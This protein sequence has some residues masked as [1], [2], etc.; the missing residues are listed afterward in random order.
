MSGVTN[1]CCANCMRVQI[2]ILFFCGSFSASFS[3][4]FSGSFSASF[5]GSALSPTYYEGQND[6]FSSPSQLLFNG[7]PALGAL[8]GGIL[9]PVMYTI[10]QNKRP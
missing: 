9:P 8:T 2:C 7:R 4:S 6:M 3:R 10:S 1:V 5:S